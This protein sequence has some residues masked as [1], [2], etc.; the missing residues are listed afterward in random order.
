MTKIKLT[1]SFFCLFL[2]QACSSQPASN[3]VASKSVP[4][5]IICGSERLDILLPYL[6][7]KK[8]ALLVNQTAMVGTSH[9]V[10]TLLGSKINIKK[11]H[12]FTF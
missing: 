12:F 10:D 9:L 3:Q 1:V 11:R 7:G 4:Q 6:E 2:M 8:V 5:S